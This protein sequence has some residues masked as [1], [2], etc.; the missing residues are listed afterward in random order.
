VAFDYVSVADDAREL[1]QD[2]GTVVT[3]NSLGETPA[4]T[5]KP[6]D[7]PANPR[8]P[9]ESSA[10][11]PIVAVPPSRASELGMRTIKQDLL[12]RTTEIWIVAA[13]PAQNFDVSKAEEAVRAG[14]TW[15][16]V[17]VE[18]LRPAVDTVLYF[19]G[20]SR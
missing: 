19:V 17:F 20:V 6:W 13:D 14:Q 5:S 7:G 18:T 11:L 12:S 9:V 8:A 10:S 3:F 1:V 15:Q 2:F 16:I 4:D